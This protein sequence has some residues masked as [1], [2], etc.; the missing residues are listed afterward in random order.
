M[1][2]VDGKNSVYILP[3]VRLELQGQGSGRFITA[4]CSSWFIKDYLHSSQGRRPESPQN[5]PPSLLCL[6]PPTHSVSSPLF[7]FPT[8]PPAPLLP[9]SSLPLCIPP[10]LHYLFSPFP[11]HVF[12]NSF[13]SARSAQRFKLAKTLLS[14]RYLYYILIHTILYILYM[15]IYYI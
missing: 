7:P 8:L 9:S 15:N 3:F 6:P 1:C 2:W 11:H 10:P 13:Q 4:E 5:R 14:L 12:Y